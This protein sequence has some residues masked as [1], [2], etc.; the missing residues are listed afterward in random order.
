[1]TN[2]Q[3][4]WKVLFLISILILTGFLSFSPTVTAEEDN[5]IGEEKIREEAR[6]KR[7]AEKQK[8]IKRQEAARIK[9]KSEE[10]ERKRKEENAF[11]NVSNKAAKLGYK[12]VLKDGIAGFLYR[13]KHGGINLE[14]GLGALLWS[15]RGSA[16]E[17][18]DKKFT[19]SQVLEDALI[20]DLSELNDDELIQFTIILPKEQG[21]LY[22][23]GQVLLGE[24][25][26]YTG[27]ITY[28]TVLGTNKTVPVFK[29][30]EIDDAP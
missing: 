18:L 23:E 30:V 13:V 1:M 25:F 2:F 10:K 28:Q 16:D 14:E 15:K 22:L 11:K 12:K 8:R 4:Y 6:I 7:E 26:T 29:P 21:K 19:I 20:Y 27:N 5:L 17:R 24:F 3:R 9:S